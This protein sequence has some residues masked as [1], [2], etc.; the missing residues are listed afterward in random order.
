MN[1]LIA[2]FSK[3]GNTKLLAEQIKNTLNS[4]NLSY[5]FK[6]VNNLD[7]NNLSS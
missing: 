5:D 7:F 3:S 6:D 4:K 1:I 2:Y